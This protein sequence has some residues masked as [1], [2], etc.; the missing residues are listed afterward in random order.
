[1]S[2]GVEHFAPAQNLLAIDKRGI[3]LKTIGKIPKRS[4]NHE[5]RAQI[6]SKGWKIENRWIDFIPYK[7]NPEIKSPEEY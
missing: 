7:A 6:P 2:A 3:A 4:A 1:M 5:T